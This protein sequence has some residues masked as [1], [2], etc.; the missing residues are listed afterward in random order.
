[1]DFETVWGEFWRGF[2]RGLGAFGGPW[3]TLSR[4]LGFIFEQ[5]F[6]IFTPQASWCQKEA[7]REDL[8]GFGNDFGG[9]WG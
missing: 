6:T 4:F 9:V 5:F 8:E 2:G 7:P 1:M 3:A